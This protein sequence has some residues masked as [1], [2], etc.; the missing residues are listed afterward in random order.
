[1]AVLSSVIGRGTLAA[2]PAAGNAGRLYFATDGSGTLYRDNGSSWDSVEGTGSGMTNPMTTA[3]DIIYGGA[4]G[5]PTRLAIGTAGQVLKVNAGATAPEWGAAS[6]GG[7]L[8]LLSSSVLGADAA[9]IT[10]TGLSG[11]YKDLVIVV[12]ARGDAA[13]D[14]GY[15]GFR[16]GSGSIDTGTNYDW[17]RSVFGSGSVINAGRGVASMDVLLHPANSATAGSFG[18]NEIVIFDYASTSKFRILTSL[19]YMTGAT[20]HYA[21]RGGGAWRNTAN[22]ID[23]VRVLPISGNLRAGSAMYVYGRG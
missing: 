6:G 9:D 10:I 2:R 21:L 7:S 17:T 13:G 15:L 23:Q 12:R 19:G 14:Y 5:T 3:G 11:A 22:A 8:V 16:V 18:H 4:S 1:V 20:D